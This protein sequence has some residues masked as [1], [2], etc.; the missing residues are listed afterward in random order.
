MLLSTQLESGAIYIGGARCSATA[1]GWYSGV[2][3]ERQ[4]QEAPQQQLVGATGSVWVLQQHSLCVR[5]GGGKG[6]YLTKV[7]ERA[8]SLAESVSQ[9]WSESR[10]E[11]VPVDVGGLTLIQ[12]MVWAVRTVMSRGRTS[13]WRCGR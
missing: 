12:S 6:E 9:L 5:F 2:P 3:L 13:P 8:L 1:G 10:R 11:S 4:S 7:T